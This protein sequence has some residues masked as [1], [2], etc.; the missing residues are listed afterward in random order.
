M[1]GT[2]DP[3]HDECWRFIEKLMYII[4]NSGFTADL[5]TETPKC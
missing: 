5:A 3:L 2:G 1:T 4:L